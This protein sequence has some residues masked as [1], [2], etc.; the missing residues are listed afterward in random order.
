M[1]LFFSPI[2]PYFGTPDLKQLQL[3]AERCWLLSLFTISTYPLWGCGALESIQA[4]IE[5]EVHQSDENIFKY[6]IESLAIWNE[7]KQS[8]TFLQ[9]Y[10]KSYIVLREAMWKSHLVIFN[11]SKNG[12]N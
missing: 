4:N 5:V 9:N 8:T 3:S 1:F 12:G 11:T 6:Q 2:A 7:T 10:F